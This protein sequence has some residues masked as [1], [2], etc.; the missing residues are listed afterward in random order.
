[1]AQW[2]TAEATNTGL[3]VVIH[4]LV[5][6]GNN[7]TRKAEWSEVLKHAGYNEGTVI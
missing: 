1:M 4:F 7:A 6:T 5:P 2:H 3:R